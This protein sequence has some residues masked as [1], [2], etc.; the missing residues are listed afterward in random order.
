M[1][2]LFSLINK[3][4]TIFE[5]L[6]SRQRLFYRDEL[7]SAVVNL[8]ADQFYMDINR[9]DKKF[10]ELDEGIFE[11]SEIS[12]NN[13]NFFEADRYEHPD[14]AASTLAQIVTFNRISDQYEITEEAI[15]EE[16]PLSISRSQEN[17]ATII[18]LNRKLNQIEDFIKGKE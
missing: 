18:F 6:L 17:S 13:I 1:N 5:P 16:Y 12:K 8:S 2:K 15:L 11:V 10:K 4:K 3:R 7:P 14:I 9:L